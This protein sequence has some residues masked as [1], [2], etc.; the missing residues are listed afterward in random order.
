MPANQPQVPSVSFA[1]CRVQVS[2]GN[3]SETT[4]SD[5]ADPPPPA[6]P[7][8]PQ[9]H[10]T[11]PPVEPPPSLISNNPNG[12]II[13]QLPFHHDSNA[14]TSLT[15]FPLNVASHA[16]E[17]SS[18]NE[19][20]DVPSL[21]NSVI[22]ITDRPRVFGLRSDRKSSVQIQKWLTSLMDGGANI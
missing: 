13:N 14:A 3:A 18:F 1:T 2:T 4:I 9:H 15:G 17:Q 11:L 5:H 8:E 10:V 19:E 6:A 20:P 7:D 21:S 16:Q 12:Y 22:R